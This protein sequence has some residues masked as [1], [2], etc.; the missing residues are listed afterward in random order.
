MTS[1]TPHK[2][3]SADLAE[4]CTSRRDVLR[5]L[6]GIGVTAIGAGV[7]V[8]CS[9][10][11]DG[12]TTSAATTAPA[13]AAGVKMSEVPLGQ[14]RVVDF[15]GRRVVV[16]QAVEGEF[17]AYSAL[18]THKGVALKDTGGMEVHCPAHGSKFDG[19]SGDV[20]KGPAV[21]SLAPIQVTVVGDRIVPA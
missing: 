3:A 8:A 13:A 9:G 20:L 15:A 7:L 16:A 21:K 5:K 6:A 2:P 19:L 17:V 12:G 4:F 14:A 18:C 10:D 11:G 1:P